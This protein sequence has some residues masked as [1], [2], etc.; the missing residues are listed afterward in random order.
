MGAGE[1]IVA[2][3]NAPLSTFSSEPSGPQI[4]FPDRIFRVLDSGLVLMILGIIGGILA[5]FLDG[6]YLLSLTPIL[7]LTIRRVKALEGLRQPTPAV[8][9]CI[10]TAFFA[11]ALFASGTF[12]NKSRQGVLTPKDWAEM[13]RNE[14][15]GTVSTT[16][17]NTMPQ[18]SNLHSGEDDLLLQ[19]KKELKNCNGFLVHS[20]YREAHDYGIGQS[21]EEEK[22]KLKDFNRMEQAEPNP[23]RPPGAADTI[24]NTYQSQ[25]ARLEGIFSDRE[26]KAWERTYGPEFQPAYSRMI[27]GEPEF[28]DFDEPDPFKSPTTISQVRFEC[29]KLGILIPKYEAKPKP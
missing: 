4:T 16:V 26:L 18:Q 2:M 5:T 3:P 9:Y 12:L 19:A 1:R 6:L 7:L 28:Q 8:V 10:A 17:V 21:I 25:I 24:R 20:A 14:P 11:A 27:E 15:V 23:N 22:R 29:A 13:L